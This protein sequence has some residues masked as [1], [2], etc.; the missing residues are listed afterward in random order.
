MGGK[1]AVFIMAR[2]G[3]FWPAA[4]TMSRGMEIPAIAAHENVGMVN[5][6]TV[7]PKSGETALMAPVSQATR[8]PNPIATNTA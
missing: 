5:S 2:P 8:T 1:S 4:V 7:N 3:A 6:G